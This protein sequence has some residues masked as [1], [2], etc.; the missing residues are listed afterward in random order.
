M[1]ITDRDINRAAIVRAAGFKVKAF[2]L[3]CS[4]RCAFEYE[5]SEAV[6]QLVHDYEAGGGLPVSLKNVL[7]NRSIL[8]SEC[9]DRR[10]GRI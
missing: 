8:L 6:R 2:K 3:Q 5:D 4:P 9:K 7:V 1:T 10:E